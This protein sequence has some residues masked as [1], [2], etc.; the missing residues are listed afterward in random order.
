MSTLVYIA[1][2]ELTNGNIRQVVN[3]QEEAADKQHQAWPNHGFVEV[4]KGTDPHTDAID[5]KTLKVVPRIT[6]TPADISSKHKE[7]ADHVA[8]G[9]FTSNATGTAHVYCADPVD[10]ALAAFTGGLIETKD[11]QV[12]HTEEQARQVLKD[13]ADHRKL[14]RQHYKAFTAKINT[15]TT[16]AYLA[17]LD[18]SKTIS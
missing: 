9:E 16:K 8:S 6:V 7:L 12:E 2:Y 3:C 11:G 17:S 4:P 5:L 10:L 1:V 18:P 13:F 14:M 15:A